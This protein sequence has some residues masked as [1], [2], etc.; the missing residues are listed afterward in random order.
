MKAQITDDGQLQMDAIPV[1]MF[2]LLKT[3]R[4]P[5]MKRAK[6]LL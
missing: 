4:Y 6:L 3:F 5:Y 1:Q 2:T